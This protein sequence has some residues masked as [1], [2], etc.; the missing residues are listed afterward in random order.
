MNNTFKATLA[1]SLMAALSVG[2]WADRC[3]NRRGGRARNVSWNQGQ[4]NNGNANWNRP[5]YNN[6]QCNNGAWNQPVYNNAQWN[7]GAWNQPVYN[8]GQCNNG[9]WN[10]PVYR[11]G[12]NQGYYNPA[13]DIGVQVLQGIVQ[14]GVLNR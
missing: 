1:I 11:P 14:S 9:A 13:A 12:W 8:N 5:V 6:G 7:N 3:H 10:Q 2:A 4:C